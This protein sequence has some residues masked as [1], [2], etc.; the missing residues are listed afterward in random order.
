MRTPFLS[1]ILIAIMACSAHAQHVRPQEPKPPFPYRAVDVHV[2]VHDPESGEQTHT[3]GATITLP[4]P[5]VFGDG[6]YV[7]V[8]LMSGS[9]MQD[10]NCEIAWHK[11]FLLIA[12]QLTRHGIAVLRYDD[13]VI[14]EST[15]LADGLTTQGLAHDGLEA[16][17]FLMNYEGI[18]P[19]RVGVLGH[20]EGGMQV[21]YVAAQ[22]DSIA[23]VISLAGVG[24][25]GGELLVDQTARIYRGANHDEAY[26]EG[27]SQRRQAIFDAIAR[28]ASDDE[29][30]ELIVELNMHEFGIKE[31][32][33]M[34][35]KTSRGLLEQFAGSWMR[36]FVLFDSREYWAEIEVPA[37]IMNG[38]LDVQVDADLN[39]GGIRD[40]LKKGNRRGYT[41]V[42]LAGLNHLFQ[43]AETGKMGEY[44]TIE[45][46]F[47]PQALAIIEAW[48]RSE[49]MQPDEK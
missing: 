2:P 8:V 41:I 13:R 23:F 39:L 1:L 49:M 16:A 48:I 30:V 12:D 22:D 14:G 35:L 27:S 47:A 34:L 19:E 11:P 31:R 20:S 37:L 36:S 43:H 29:I 45:E 4:D 40:A 17:R 26:I 38:T 6:P 21:P 7:G 15:G 18:D 25:T 42:E 44:G 3:L 10:R 33:E 28:D 5:A 24:V 46:T 32:N 9:G